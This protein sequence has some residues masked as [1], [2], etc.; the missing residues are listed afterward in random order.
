MCWAESRAS[1][2][3]I[4]QVTFTLSPRIRDLTF[5]HLET[6]SAED[7]YLKTF[8]S[9]GVRALPSGQVL[10]DFWRQHAI[11]FAYLAPSE[12]RTVEF[13]IP[14]GVV[15]L[16]DT[17][18]NTGPIFVVHKQIDPQTQSVA[19]QLS[20]GKFHPTDHEL[21]PQGMHLGANT[22]KF[23]QVGELHS[24]R[25]RLTV[26]NQMDERC[27]LAARVGCRLL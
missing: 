8:I 26:K 10:Q 6:L 22:F 20:K 14:P 9:K 27:S 7:L 11:L 19:L 4:I 3:D 5:H 17:L 23:E 12:S 21:A 24:G 13:D 25:L 18:H 16:R 2:D 15:H 1:L